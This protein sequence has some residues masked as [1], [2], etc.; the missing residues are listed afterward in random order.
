MKKALEAKGHDLRRRGRLQTRRLDFSSQVAR[1]KAAGV[2]LIVI[3][4]VTRET[5]GI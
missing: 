2:E 1:M 5:V 3:A 4:T